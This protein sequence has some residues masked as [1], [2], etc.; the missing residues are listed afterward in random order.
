MA[1][2]ASSYPSTTS[3]PVQLVLAFGKADE[4]TVLMEWEEP[5][6]AV[7][8]V[9]QLRKATGDALMVDLPWE[10]DGAMQLSGGTLVVVGS[11][12]LLT[13]LLGR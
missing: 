2:Y 10:A 9:L 12:R 4:E 8:A 13:V 1:P 7:D 6:A 3:G 5:V 11:S